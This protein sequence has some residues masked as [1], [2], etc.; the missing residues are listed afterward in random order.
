M[1]PQEHSVYTV[2]VADNKFMLIANNYNRNNNIAFYITI[3]SST[4]SFAKNEMWK[5]KIIFP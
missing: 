2:M 4:L 3:N 1:N 5:Y